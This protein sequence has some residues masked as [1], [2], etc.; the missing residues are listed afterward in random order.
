MIRITAIFLLLSYIALTGCIASTLPK[1]TK[2][3]KQ[4]VKA[5]RKKSFKDENK[6]LHFPTHILINGKDINVEGFFL[7][8]TGYSKKEVI[9]ILGKPNDENKKVGTYI[10]YMSIDCFSPKKL[11]R[12]F[13]I[14]FN[15]EEKTINAFSPPLLDAT[16]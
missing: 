10:Y 4:I 2:E 14:V 3:E 9:K 7:G 5:I 6:L 8:F 1:R 11:C 13:T 15:K 16:P 12:N